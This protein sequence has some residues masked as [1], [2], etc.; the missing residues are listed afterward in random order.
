MRACN[1][2]LQACAMP[3]GLLQCSKK[4]AIFFSQDSAGSTISRSAF[5]KSS[6]RSFTMA[7]VEKPCADVDC[8]D[9]P[10]LSLHP[11]TATLHGVGE[12][13]ANNET[14]G[15]VTTLQNSRGQI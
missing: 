8:V 14:R 9:G 1:L 11:V 4:L 15:C 12:A 7:L 2:S 3:N 5:S 6:H 10:W 13:D